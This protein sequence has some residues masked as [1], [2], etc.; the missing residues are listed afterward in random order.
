MQ[1]TADLY[2]LCVFGL[3]LTNPLMWY[4]YLK[5]VHLYVTGMG[6]GLRKRQGGL[7]AFIV[8]RDSG[9]DAGGCADEWWC[10]WCACTVVFLLEYQSRRSW[11]HK[12]TSQ[13][14][15]MLFR[16]GNIKGGAHPNLGLSSGS[17]DTE[18]LGLLTSHRPSTLAIS[19]PLVEQSIT[20]MNCVICLSICM[21]PD[22][23]G[24]LLSVWL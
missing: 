24:E 18:C 7:D 22:L 17:S 2:T 6:Y 19:V 5:Y 3:P 21:Y 16:E 4:K 13:G 14:S 10:I 9:I 1:K 8:F 15:L 12:I 20:R 11:H 23:S